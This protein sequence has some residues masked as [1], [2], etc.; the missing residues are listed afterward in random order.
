V[1]GLA[2]W[3]QAHDGFVVLAQ[4]LVWALCVAAAAPSLRRATAEQPRWLLLA[5]PILGAAAAAISLFAIP[6]LAR[7]APLGHEASYFDCYTG[8]SPPGSEGGWEPYVT[9]PLLRW[10]YWA[11]GRLVP[12]DTP[13]AP[14]ILNAAVRGI[15]VVLIGGVGAVLGKR[16]EVG[17]TAA[18]LLCLHSVHAFWGGGMFNVVLPHALA[19]LCVLFALLAWRSG[20]VRPM[21]AAAASGAMVVA[22]RVEWALLAP[23]LGALLLS[24]GPRWGRALGVRRARFWIGPLALS[25]AFALAL[26]LGAGDLTEQ[27]GYHDP[28]GYLVTLLHQVFLLEIFEPLH[29]AWALAG[30][31]AGAAMWWKRGDVDRSGPFGLLAFAL[32]SW[33]GLATFNDVSYRHALVPAIALLLALALLAP[34]LRGP[35]PGAVIAATFLGLTIAGELGALKTAAHRYYM[36]PEAFVEEHPGFQGPEIAAD[37][38]DGSG[39]Y[40]ITD[41]ERLWR[42]GIA[43]SH[44]NLMDPGEAVKRWRHHGGC[45][46]WLYDLSNHRQDSLAARVRGRKLMRWFSWA[47]VGQAHLEG[48]LD[49][50]VYRMTSPPWGVQDGDPV[51]PTD[52]LMP[53]EVE[54]ED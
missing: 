19:L 54:P 18:I 7:Y 23:A 27:G 1:S 49:A 26:L 35:R 12:G 53:W 42:L 28:R 33:G 21:L 32:L 17:L 15:A 2:P 4:L 51:P 31:A 39:C 5:L 11:L 50:V 16:P 34:A 47:P 24:L 8:A 25:A 48:G 38:I 37:V 10:I 40:L 3:I 29:H 41:D 30:A 20:E 43:G 6:S 22:G 44:F 45:I 46:L 13:A 14:Q 9:Y 36:S 52:V